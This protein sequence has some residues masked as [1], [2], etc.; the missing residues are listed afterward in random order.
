MFTLKSPTLKD[1]QPIPA[2][3]ARA[4]DN[5]S[6][7]LM[8]SDPPPG[9]RSFA[10]VLE[11]ADASEP[12]FRQWVIY[13]VH[14]ARRHLPETGSRSR[15]EEGLPHGVNAFGNLH[16]DGPEPPAGD[17]PHTY[18]FRLFALSVP[19]LGLEPRPHAADVMDG[20]R[21]NLLGEAELT[22]TYQVIPV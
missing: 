3:N 12:A 9:T 22:G 10:L 18:R 14:R 21:A 4:G 16:Y 2:R 17:P 20:V 7:E 15:A 5:V 8:W 1:G 6:P 13:D 11:D 19:T